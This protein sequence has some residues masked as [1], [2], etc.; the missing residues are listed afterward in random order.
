[1]PKP[2]QKFVV[3]QLPVEVYASNAELGAA[4]AERAL[5]IL[6]EAIARRGH[7]NLVLATGNSQLYL[8]QNLCQAQGVDWSKVEIFHMDEY[9]GMPADHP[10]SFRRFLQERIIQHIHPAAFYGVQGDAPDWQAECARYTQLL[11]THPVDLCCLGIGENGHI[12][13]ND[14]P[15]ALFN[16]PEWVKVVQLDERSRRQQVGE[17]HFPSLADVPTHALTLTIPAL[18]SAAAM[19]CIA[20]ERRKAEAVKAALEGPLTETCPAS[21]L[22]RTPYCRLFLDTDSAALL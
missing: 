14:P 21:I 13:F 10:A 2:V 8:L 16:D 9:A 5:M 12:A 20:P 18:R 6:Q 7:A 3:E 17:G 4:A 11:K 22:R 15:Y 1:M 19:L